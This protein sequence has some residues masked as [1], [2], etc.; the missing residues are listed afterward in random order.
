MKITEKQEQNFWKRVHKSDTGCWEWTGC[1]CHGYGYVGMNGKN[2]R[3]H[4][5][6]YILTHGG[7]PD[8]L[9]P[10]HLCKNKACVNPAHL[11][12]VTIKENTMRGDGPTAQNAKKTHCPQGHEYTPEN[13]HLTKDNFRQCKECSR[14]RAREYYY[15]RKSL[16][17]E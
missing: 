6:A 5:I 14:R 1:K 16:G 12:L 13:T 15:R 2:H 3:V 10:D 11:E 9:V 8:G 17:T 7:I 4:R